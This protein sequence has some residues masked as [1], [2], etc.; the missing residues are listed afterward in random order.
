[1]I[2]RAVSL[3][4]LAFAMPSFA[5]I[6]D[7]EPTQTIIVTG[8]ASIP[9]RNV[10][11]VTRIDRARLDHS[12]S[13]RL[14]TCSATCRIQHLRLIPLGQPDQP[15]RHPARFGG[16]RRAGAADPD[17]VPLSDPFGGWISWPAL[18]PRSSARSGSSRRRH[19]RQ[20]SG[21][22]AG[23]IE[24]TSAAPDELGACRRAASGSR[25][26]RRLA[27]AGGARRRLRQRFRRLGPGRRL[28][29]G[30][31]GP[32]RSA[33]Q[34]RPTAGQRRG[35]GGDACLGWS[36]AQAN[37][38]AFTDARA[39]HR[40]ARSTPPAPTVAAAGRARPAFPRFLRAGPRLLQ[41]VRRGQCRP[42]SRPDPGSIFVP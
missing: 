9:G 24:L 18:D 2:S 34:P 20:G 38:A 42:R 17:G 37:L 13:D 16:N 33:D 23:T 35:A 4:L 36:R 5:A 19:R 30:D 6:Q 21:A 28:H 27:G 1:M 12:P 39:R 15:G 22:L 32:A 40:S 3:S 25:D 8:A 41:R 31:R 7:G 26:C 11:D 10:Y 29:S 14:R